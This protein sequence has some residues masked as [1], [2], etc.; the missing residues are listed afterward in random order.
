MT[1]AASLRPGRAIW[2]GWRGILF[3]L[4]GH[5]FVEMSLSDSVAAA[6]RARGKVGFLAILSGVLALSAC[7]TV[8]PASDPGA[9][10]EYRQNNDPLEPTNRV[11]YKA[12]DAVDRAVIK[13][14]AQGYVAVVP[15][16]VRTHI[17]DFL[18]NFDIPVT[19]ANDM[20]QAR[21]RAAGDSFARFLI[22]STVGVAGIFDVATG[23]G[24]PLH[25]N[26][27]G[28]T[29]ASWGAGSGP[30]LFLPGL[31]PSDLRDGVGMGVD[32]VLNPLSFPLPT[33]GAWQDFGYARMGISVVDSRARYLP[34]TNDINAT[35]LDPYATFR[36]LFQQHR[37]QQVSEARKPRQ[38]GTVP[39]WFPPPAAPPAAPTA[40]PSAAATAK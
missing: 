24:Y 38:P 1:A 8:P 21:P 25:E 22:N 32:S 33:S 35:A 30:Y 36:S 9:L 2:H 19:F 20:L 15:S 34:I 12:S 23:W 37:A 40:A 10:A 18:S 29:M 4:W 7:A 3:C 31:G 27:F 5:G 17:H 39:D 11:I 6:G 14:V 16:P 28:L 26:D 13:P